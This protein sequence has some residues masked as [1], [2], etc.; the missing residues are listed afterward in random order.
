MS[1]E[2]CPTTL[3]RELSIALHHH[4]GPLMGGRRLYR[5]L[6]YDSAEIFRASLS[7]G[8]VPVPVFPIAG[9]RGKF[10]LTVDVVQWLVEARG[11]TGIL[12]PPAEKPMDP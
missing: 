8:R 12:A 3:R 11:Q 9:R 4:Y 2:L 6:G 10:A 5:A 7:R 1:A